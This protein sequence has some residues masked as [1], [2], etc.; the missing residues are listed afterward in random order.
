MIGG[1]GGKNFAPK[2]LSQSGKTPVKSKMGFKT[3][4][5]SKTKDQIVPEDFQDE[6]D[7]KPIS[8]R[9]LF[10]KTFKKEKGPDDD[11]DKG[12]DDNKKNKK[13]LKPANTK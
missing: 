3:P 8:Y 4:F 13:K 10:S 9:N 12:Q 5:K 7:K 6:K 2:H 11:K 1:K